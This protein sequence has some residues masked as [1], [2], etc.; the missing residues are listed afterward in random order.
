MI[1]ARCG[2][3][4]STS[5]YSPL[6]VVEANLEGELTPTNRVVRIWRQTHPSTSEKNRLRCTGGTGLERPPRGHFDYRTAD[7]GAT[8]PRPPRGV[9]IHKTS[10]QADARLQPERFA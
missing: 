5:V 8:P 3:R 7:T 10:T 4:F 9:G 6:G 2:G 1:R